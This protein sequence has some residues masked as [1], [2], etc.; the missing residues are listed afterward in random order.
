MARKLRPC[1]QEQ[2]QGTTFGDGRVPQLPSRRFTWE[3]APAAVSSFHLQVLLSQ[4]QQA[5][6]DCANLVTVPKP[7]FALSHSTSQQG[8]N[9]ARS[10]QFVEAP[11]AA[12]SQHCCSPPKEPN[13]AT[14]TA[15]SNGIIEVP[16]LTHRF[17]RVYWM[18]R[19][20]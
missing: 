19:Q 7:P 12:S 1:L 9:P 6:P 13:R 14:E 16:L 20:T 2:Q 4:S 11:V 5:K 18:P 3:L 8:S 17:A 10:K 15:R